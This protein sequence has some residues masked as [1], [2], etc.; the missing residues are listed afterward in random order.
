KAILY[1]T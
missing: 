1:A